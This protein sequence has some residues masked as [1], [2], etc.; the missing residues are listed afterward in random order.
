DVA[1]WDSTYLPIFDAAGVV[2]GVMT[3]D[4]DVT[5]SVR[6]RREM[7]RINRAKDEFL[8]TMSHELRTPLNA[9]HGW[10]TIL[11]KKPLELGALDRGLAVIERNVQTQARLVSDL[12]D[13]SRIVTGKLELRLEQAAV[14][15]LIIAAVDIVRPAAEAR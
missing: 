9:I 5:E 7:E 8:A 3:V 2:E 12:L 11:Q 15:P 6:T 4:L 14:Y 10:T 13:V 1:Y